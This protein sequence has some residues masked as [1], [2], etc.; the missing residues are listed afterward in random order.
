MISEVFPLTIA[1]EILRWKFMKVL[2]IQKSQSFWNETVTAME[3]WESDKLPYCTRKPWEVFQSG[4]QCLWLAKLY[5][6]FQ[7]WRYYP[8]RLSQIMTIFY[9]FNSW[10]IMG[11]ASEANI[12]PGTLQR[13]SRWYAELF[14]AEATCDF[15]FFGPRSSRGTWCH[16]LQAIWENWCSS[17]FCGSQQGR[18]R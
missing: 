6:F 3:K 15:L 16:L 18:P 10:E 1:I 2:F 5:L 11:A 14:A 17:S 12:Y 9:T 7:L 4:V 13:W 8:H